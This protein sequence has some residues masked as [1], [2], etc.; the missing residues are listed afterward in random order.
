MVSSWK[1]TWENFRGYQ[2][3]TEFEFPKI[4][5]LIG[6]N[7]VGKTSA[8]APLLLLKQTLD[9][10]D[11]RTN[12]LTRGSLLDAGTFKEIVYGHDSDR[13]LRFKMDL[14]L[15]DLR[16][17]GRDSRP[18][19][20]ASLDISFDARED[21]L[22]CALTKTIMSDRSGNNIVKRIKNTKKDSWRVSAPVLPP[23]SSGGRPIREISDFSRALNEEMPHG[24]LF[25][26]LGAIY[27]PSKWRK[28]EQR[29]EAARPW[30]DAVFDLYDIQS[31]FNHTFENRLRNISYLGPLR[32]LPSRT[33]RISPEVPSDVGR[34]G[35]F[36][37][38]LLMRSDNG[39][40]KR[41]VNRWLST[42]GYGDLDFRQL[43]DDFFQVLVRSSRDGIEVNLSHTGIG[44]SQLLPILVQGSLT[45]DGDTFIVQQPE[46]H[47]NPA[48]Q[49]IITDF[50]VDRAVGGTRTIVETHSEHLLLRLRRRIAEGVISA[51]DVAVYYCDNINDV[52]TAERI[53]IGERAE[54]NIQDWP[55]GF[56]EEQLEDSFALALAQAGR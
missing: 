17:R 6:R 40:V 42:L 49:C 14:G 9:A 55:S 7:N 12:L 18:I 16:V 36:A 23:R 25:S 35:Q 15:G 27:M 54:L 20:D 24:F 44:L 21:G 56:F 19:T 33:Y 51:Q 11:R 34:D 50:L 52:S 47:L 53:S 43:G 48:Q 4:T 46:I 26:G 31:S 28:D 38:E 32:S 37:P 41:S 22:S 5:L 13:S 29:W 39:D 2:N 3:P 45:R 30:M 8:Y 1:V 10:K